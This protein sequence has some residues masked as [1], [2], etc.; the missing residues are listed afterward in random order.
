MYKKIFCI[1]LLCIYA[2]LTINAEKVEG[3]SSGFGMTGDLYSGSCTFEAGNVVN[4][5]IINAGKTAVKVDYMISAQKETEVRS[6]ALRIGE[7][8]QGGFQYDVVPP[9]I[10]WY[11]Y[12]ALDI[13]D[14]QKK[15]AAVLFN[16]R[17]GSYETPEPN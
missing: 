11:I 12:A 9:P 15:L 4:F 5:D 3:G 6:Q 13:Y 1:I 2:T 10:S 14:F 16:V 7:S 17:W 8:F